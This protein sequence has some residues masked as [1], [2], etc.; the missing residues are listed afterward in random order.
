MMA[1]TAPCSAPDGLQKILLKDDG[2]CCGL[3][4][5]AQRLLILTA[6]PLAFMEPA[7][8]KSIY[9]NETKHDAKKERMLSKSS[10]SVN[11]QRINYNLIP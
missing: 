6:G 4:S 7:T 3:W 9:I 1:K 5:T 2:Y 10:F 11:D 8:S